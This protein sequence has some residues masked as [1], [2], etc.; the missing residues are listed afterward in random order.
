VHGVVAVGQCIVELARRLK[1]CQKGARRI[2]ER[3]R[4]YR[5]LHCRPTA[6][7]RPYPAILFI[8]GG[9]GRAEEPVPAAAS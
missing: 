9:N 1:L 7:R 3:N 2:R 6:R 8:F 4:R 5:L